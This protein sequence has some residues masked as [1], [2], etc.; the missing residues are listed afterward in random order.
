MDRLRRVLASG[1][2]AMI[3]GMVTAASGCRS[4]KNE[5]P[6]G[7]KYSTTG[8]PSAPLSFNGDPK[9]SYNALSS[10]YGNSSAPGQTGLPS[11]SGIG[12]GMGPASNGMSPPGLGSG[13]GPSSF[14][15]PPPSSPGMGTPTGNLYGGPGTSGMPQ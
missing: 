7:P 1:S 12:G 2:L 5:V 6:P 15:T 11:S 9:P 4:T 3:L 14:G 10:P 13:G 8:N